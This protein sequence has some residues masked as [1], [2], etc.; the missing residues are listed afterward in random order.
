MKRD[1]KTLT[2]NEMVEQVLDAYFEWTVDH[3]RWTTQDI[4]DNLRDTLELDKKEVFQYM[5]S[6][7]WCLKRVDERLV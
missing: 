1:M 3:G 2:R 5:S 7:G 6:K 4:I